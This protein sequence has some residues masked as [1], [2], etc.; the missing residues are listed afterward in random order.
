MILE[1][2][3]DSALDESRR[4]PGLD[5]PTFLGGRGD[6]PLGTTTLC[7][8]DA[9]LS[10]CVF[11]GGTELELVPPDWVP[12]LRSVFR[13][14]SREAIRSR[15]NARL[16]AQHRSKGWK[17]GSGSLLRNEFEILLES[18]SKGT[19]YFRKGVRGSWS[20]KKGKRRKNLI[21]KLHLIAKCGVLLTNRA[22]LCW[23]CLLDK[24]HA[25][26][27]LR[28][29]HFLFWAACIVTQQISHMI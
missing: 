19:S 4:S 24:Q 2:P 22:R 12:V 18:L 11:V 21:P 10:L 9:G 16:G 20:S 23:Q 13:T 3:G 5:A 29:L 7:S 1:E 27:W 15:V 26:D 6:C 28:S 25:L 17:E 14:T 8:R